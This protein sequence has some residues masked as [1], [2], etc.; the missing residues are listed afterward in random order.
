M[1]IL[2]VAV[3]KAAEGAETGKQASSALENASA[4]IQASAFLIQQANPDADIQEALDN[5]FGENP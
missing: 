2:T 4:A 3:D 1:R 5:V